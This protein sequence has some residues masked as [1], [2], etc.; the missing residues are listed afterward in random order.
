MLFEIA[1][2][3]AL[4]LSNGLLA[5]GE[6][7]VVS[8]RKALLTELSERGQ[9]GAR[10]A[11]RLAADPSR[12]LAAVQ[13]GITL[14]GAVAGVYSGARLVPALAA[15]VAQL[16]VAGAYADAVGMTVVVLLLTFFSLVLGEL[17]PK[18]LALRNAEDA[19]SLLA[20]PLQLM[21][22]LASPFTRTLSGSSNLV[23]RLFKGVVAPPSAITEEELKV[24]IDHATEAG[25]MRES[26]QDMMKGVLSL[27]DLTAKDLMTPRHEVVALDLG[28]DDQTTWAR[29]TESGHTYF[30]VV[31]GEASNIIGLVSIK[32]LIEHHLAGKPLN[33]RERA[34]PPLF[35]PETV[36]AM[37]V[38]E[39]FKIGK[40]HMAF[41]VDEHGGIEGIITVTDVL[42]AV[43]GDMPTMGED[44]EEP[45]IVARDDGSFL[46]DGR[47]AITEL[48]DALRIKSLPKKHAGDYATVGGLI[49]TRLGR[50]PNIADSFRFRGYR[51]EVVGMDKRRVDK[52]LVTKMPRKAPAGPSLSGADG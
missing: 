47:T 5:M 2:V 35:L 50:I 1:F 16:P 46:V 33:L 24:M 44:A 39:K 20:R 48:M 27:G 43:V 23:L 41:V 36:P 32:H 14:L 26:E 3:A 52:V 31:D 21:S 8:A 4:L 7:A 15:Q 28:D 22:R 25:V 51:F 45:L 18:Q 30:P 34:A 11:L 12:F 37:K 42:K 10:I 40:T 9:R 13:L 17:V 6:I 38:M 49:M 29:I 19:A